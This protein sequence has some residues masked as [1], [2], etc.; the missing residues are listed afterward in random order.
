[1]TATTTRHQSHSHPLQD[2]EL[3]RRAE[4]GNYSGFA[5][6][7]FARGYEAGALEQLYPALHDHIAI[8]LSH[9]QDKLDAEAALAKLLETHE[10]VEQKIQELR[11]AL[12]S[13]GESH[14]E[15]KERKN[16]HHEWRQSVE[17]HG[18]IDSPKLQLLPARINP[19]EKS[20]RKT[21]ANAS[22]PQIK[23]V[24]LALPPFT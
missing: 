18:R 7:I 14:A 8:A 6:K 15:A 21:S 5:N 24:S 2:G 10:K 12:V 1:M 19:V 3:A 4:D 20:S 11:S 16:E 17:R 9:Y 22:I 13:K 23:V